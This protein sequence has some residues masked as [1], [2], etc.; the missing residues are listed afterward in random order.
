MSQLAREAD[1]SVLNDSDTAWAIEAAARIVTA[2]YRDRAVNML[3]EYD[4]L[5]QEA[6][7]LVATNPALQGLEPSLLRY[8]LVQDLTDLVKYG[9]ERANNTVYLST[10]EDE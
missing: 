6:R 3:A 10:L 9:A 2:K 5:I 1:W 4:D 8:R 7:I